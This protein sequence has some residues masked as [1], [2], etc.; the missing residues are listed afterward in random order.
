MAHDAMALA[1]RLI[2]QSEH[3]LTPMQIIKLVYICHGWMLGL[4]K[5]PLIR[6]PVEA[7]RYGP[8]V[9]D[10]YQGFK[11]YGGEHIREPT[12]FNAEEEF[13][14]YEEDLYRQV[15]EK[16]GDLSGIALSSITHA[17]GTPWHIVW[18]RNGQNAVIPNDL[19]QEYYTQKAKRAANG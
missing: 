9:S 18:H 15:V 14:E 5:R 12:G 17:T 1:N 19:I 11:R 7:W 13:D 8:V 2:D 6:Q 4:Y 10:V 3:P 16:Y